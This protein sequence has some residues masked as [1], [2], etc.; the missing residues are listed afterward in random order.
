MITVNIKYTRDCYHILFFLRVIKF[1][2][3]KT[4]QGVRNEASITV[5]IKS[6]SFHG[7][8]MAINLVLHIRIAIIHLLARTEK[9]AL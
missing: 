4:L 8:L 5:V 6:W 7:T 1:I 9:R 2:L 3:P